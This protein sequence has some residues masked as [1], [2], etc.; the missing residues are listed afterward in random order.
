MLRL[1]RLALLAALAA[2]ATLAAAA[3]AVAV[4]ATTEGNRRAARADT[5]LTTE[6]NRHAARADARQLLARL[7]LPPGARR[8]RHHPSAPPAELVAD[9]AHAIASAWWRV[10]GRPAAVLAYIRSHRPAGATLVATGT[11]GERGVVTE[12]SLGYQWPA[13]PG[14]LGE[15]LLNVT[16]TAMRGASAVFAEAQSDWIV[17]RSRAERVP[18]GVRAVAITAP[19]GAF[20][21][22]AQERVRRLISL[23]DSLP[24]AQPVAY[25]C[26]E[27]SAADERRVTFTFLRRVSGPP[28]AR[29]V[30]VGFEPQPYLS[31]PCNAIAFSVRGRRMTPLIG[32]NRFLRSAQR[33]AGR[34]LIAR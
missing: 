17:V 6:G 22:T 3:A 18:S 28:L 27:Q 10:P 31:Y 20:V 29:A 34:A 4:A 26:P 30:Y 16:I 19:T 5:R 9:E 25:S 2:L 14:V 21:L 23:V 12:R 13:K 11:G 15:R 24:I 7:E 1:R 32:G 8:L 33:I